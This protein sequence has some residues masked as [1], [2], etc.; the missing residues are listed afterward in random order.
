MLGHHQVFF[1]AICLIHP[2]VR[3]LC[4]LDNLPP[5]L[6]AVVHE[7][8]HITQRR[9]T[10]MIQ[11]NRLGQHI[12]NLPVQELDFPGSFQDFKLFPSFELFVE[13]ALNLLRT[14]EA[15][16]MPLLLYLDQ[17]FLLLLPIVWNL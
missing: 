10:V 7:I 14:L 1:D 15:F 3:R 16:E 12:R 17:F 4:I 2:Q 9:L 6:I 8:R 13:Q 11:D 5:S